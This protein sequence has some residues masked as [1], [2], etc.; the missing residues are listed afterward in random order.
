MVEPIDPALAVKLGAY[1]V[2]PLPPGFTERLVAAALAEPALDEL[3]K[4][5]RP[6]TRRWLRGGLGGL[7]VIAVGMISI[8]AA[9]MGY[10]GEPIRHAVQQAPV[11]GKVI[12]RVMSK[13][14]RPVRHEAP[15]RVAKPI[16]PPV[17]ATASAAPPIEEAPPARLT[18]FERRQLRRAMLADPEAR[19][20]WIEAH[21]RAAQRIARRR[22]EM[23]RRRIE[24]GMMPQA[25][26]PI[27]GP[28]PPLLRREGLTP[29]ERQERIEQLRERRRI[30]R[31]RRQMM[32]EPGYRPLRDGP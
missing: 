12:E 4:L 32:R 11:V 30:V 15:A 10:F 9:A 29:I 22:A 23:R 24:A 14:V 21:P 13:S 26:M 28:M 20:A 6:T 3:P 17:L 1:I 31:E 16:A 18:P 27:R 25:G 5:R 8:S 19:R 7:G 2:P